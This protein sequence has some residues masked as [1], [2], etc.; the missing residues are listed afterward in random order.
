MEAEKGK[1]VALKALLDF[2]PDRD[3]RTLRDIVRAHIGVRDEFLR[4]M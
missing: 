1:L 2:E 4:G 3:V